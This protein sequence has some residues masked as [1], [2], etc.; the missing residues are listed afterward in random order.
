MRKVVFL[1]GTLANGGAER[2]VSNLSLNLDENI[3]KEI[4]LFGASA[5]IDYDH[6]GKVIFLDKDLPKNPFNKLITMFRRI[7]KI[8]KLKRENPHSQ[9]I[10]FL[11][12]PNLLNMISGTTDKSIVS[13]RNYMT[14]KHNKGI[15]SLFWNYTIRRL[16]KRANKI[17]AVSNEVKNDLVNNYKLPKNKIDVI[18]NSYPLN[19]ITSLSSNN[20]PEDLKW[21]FDNPVI[22]T[23]GRLSEQKGHSHLI[24]SFKN[25]KDQIEEAQLV[26]LGEGSLEKKLRKQVKNLSL[27][28]SVHFLGFQINPFKYIARAKVFVMSSYFEGFPNAL[29]EAMACNIPVIST[30]C[31]SGPREILAPKYINGS[32]S[33]LNHHNQYGILVPDLAKENSDIVE[34]QIS[35]HAI[36]LIKDEKVWQKYSVKSYQRVKELDISK[37]IHD[38]EKLIQ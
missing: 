9:F 13:V 35:H 22:I 7:I 31:L 34:G 30:D 4:V 11:E 5:K 28:E 36:N 25:I 29:A 37:V 18:Y 3:E 19:K 20:L 17:I 16:Y 23:A 15:K 2:V 10:S 33:N 27:E 26:F 21:I 32:I 12:Y 14:V 38:W 6:N 8:R 24:N 1:I